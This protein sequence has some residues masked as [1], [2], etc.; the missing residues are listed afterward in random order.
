M[1]I[2]FE[3]LL[4]GKL[5]GELLS[6]LLRKYT[7]GDESVVVGARYGEDATVIEVG[8][9][10]LVA[11]TDPIT[12]TSDRIGVWAVHVNANDILC[13]GA[14]P[15]WFL[16]TILL[17]EH[18]SSRHS[19]EKIFSDISATCRAQKIAFCGGHTEITVDLNRPI[20][21]GQMLGEVTRECL[22]RK[23]NA[24]RGDH[25]LLVNEIPIETTA[26]L[27]FEYADELAKAYSVD[28]VERCQSM[29]ENPGI[30]VRRA[31]ET[32][33]GAG[34][35]HALHDPTEGGL[36]S[37]LHELASASDLGVEIH[38][39]EIPL[40]PEGKLL[41]DHYQL[42]PLGCI[43]SG[44]LLAI[45]PSGGTENAVAACHNHGLVAADIG[46]MTAP[47]QGRILHLNRRQLP[48]PIYPRDEILK[49]TGI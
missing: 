8:D 23:T 43:A 27:A 17:S 31:V 11:K 29:L 19:V 35:V 12:F 1:S 15:K 22:V 16:A 49:L 10:Y 48:L 5:E 14:V 6:D 9:R 39:S 33:L 34:A 32:V 26:I 46:V 28:F 30:S 36:C 24:R 2:E 38:F 13:M 20:L 7:F 4:P 44:S 37:A 42:D 3:R 41:C 18:H 45:V 47:E 40:L 25:I 21:V